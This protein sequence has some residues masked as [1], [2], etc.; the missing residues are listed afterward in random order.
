ML[1][2]GPLVEPP[3]DGPASTDTPASPNDGKGNDFAINDL[4]FKLAIND[5]RP[6]QRATA[7][8]RK[9]QFDSGQRTGDQSL[10]G[11]WTRGEFSFHKGAGITYYEVS[12]GDTVLNRYKI[13]EGVDPF[14]VGK[15]TC[16]RAWTEI[17]WA[18]DVLTIGDF[19][20]YL[21]YQDST[22]DVYYEAT[23]VDDGT[24][25]DFGVGVTVR[26]IA[27]TP[28]VI[29]ATTT[30]DEVVSVDLAGTVTVL[31]DGFA[32]PRGIHYVK[33]RLLVEC[34]DGKWYQLS[35]SPTSPPATVGPSD[36]VFTV[37]SDWTQTTMR[38]VCTTPGPIL[39]ADRNRIHALTLDATGTIPTFSAPVQVGE[40]PPEEIIYS[41]RH[42]LGFVVLTTDKGVR[43]GAL[44]DTGQ[45]TYGPLLVESDPSTGPTAVVSI[46]AYSTRVLTIVDGRLVEIDLAQQVGSGLE[47]AWTYRGDPAAPPTTY[48]GVVMVFN[49]TTPLVHG[50]VNAH[51]ADSFGDFAPGSLTTGYHRFATLENKRFDSVRVSAD[52]TFG[53]ITISKVLESGTVISLYT[54]DVS[55]AH[56]VDV[57]FGSTDGEQMIALKFDLAPAEGHE[58]VSPVLLG[59][60]IRALPEPDRQRM[61]RVPLQCFDVERRGPAGAA[62]HTGSAWERLRAL[63]QLEEANAVVAF[64]DYR[65]SEAG[66]AFIESIEF[67]NATP[68]S[69]KSSGFGGIAFATLRRIG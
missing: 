55:T 69:T 29:Y 66:R 40:L 26:S 12:E 60:Q 33:S 22:N 35:T 7:Q 17:D 9:D 8:F 4:L 38:S 65:T 56:E 48:G 1:P 53:T 52:G 59:Y 45:L 42:H 62:G 50:E 57:S 24:L 18:I 34:D 44:S 51:Y 64:R 36:V 39:V 28:N 32:T 37:G 6:Y 67:T 25:V 10:T 23:E 15:V 27:I 58:T 3:V 46:A 43:V 31:Y 68:P 2:V 49:G 41:M 63:E 61:I 5:E 13:A 11:W 47:F 14:R 20:G 16:Q 54:L 19:G 21:A 30:N